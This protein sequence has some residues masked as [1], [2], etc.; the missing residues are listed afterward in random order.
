[1]NVLFLCTGNSC[2]SQMAEGWVR[3]LA[4]DWLEVQSAGIESHGLNPLAIEAM[5]EA[6][7]D[8]ALQESAEITDEML[9]CADYL[10][11]VCG[12]ADQNCPVLPAGACKDHWPLDDPARAAGTDEHVMKVFRKC[13]DDI[14]QRVEKLIVQLRNDNGWESE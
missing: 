10:V 9:A 14:Q 12:H 4:G 11:T 8:I 3:H 1:M 13:R 2:R 5:R 6:G 7:V